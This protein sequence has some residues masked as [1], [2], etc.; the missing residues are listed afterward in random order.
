MSDTTACSNCQAPVPAAAA[1]CPSCGSSVASSS[2][3]S[4]PGA[5]TSF[6]NDDTRVDMPR[7]DHTQVFPP[8]APWSPTGSV[9]GAAA[10]P[11]NPPPAPPAPAWQQPPPG[12]TYGAPPPSAPAWGAGVGPGTPWGAPNQAPPTARTR[13]KSPLGGITALLGALLTLVGIFTPWVGNN[14]SVGVSGRGKDL[15]GWDLT[16]GN[17]FLKSLDPYILLALAIVA[18]AVA[19]ARFSGALHLIARIA[20]VVAGVAIVAILI[21]DWLSIVDVVKN[22]L[23]SSFKVKQKFGYFLAVAGGVVTAAS[24]LLPNA[25]QT[26]KR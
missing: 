1:F 18:I 12:P 15:S 20:A 6:G 23:P 26:P 17:N 3:S 14:G 8:S 19:V 2:G 24:G 21:R 16:S 22:T 25:K 4:S 11:W 5:G 13:P 9:P 7:P 10:P